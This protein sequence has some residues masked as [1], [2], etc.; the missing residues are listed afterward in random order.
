MGCHRHSA[1]ADIPRA[2]MTR[3]DAVV[4]RVL[5]DAKR[6]SWL[7]TMGRRILA[8]GFELK[9]NVGQLHRDLG[10]VDRAKNHWHA[11]TDEVN[12]HSQSGVPEM[13]LCKMRTTWACR[14]AARAY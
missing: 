4:P 5:A 3:T 12:H 13:I 2:D 1:F 14:L 7:V 8:C 9:E 10:E 11:Q 6:D